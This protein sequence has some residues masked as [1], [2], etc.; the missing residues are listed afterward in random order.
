METNP[1]KELWVSMSKKEAVTILVA[2]GYWQDGLKESGGKA[3][4][5]V[6]FQEFQTAALS[7]KEL[8][9]LTTR[10]RRNL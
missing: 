8:G 3:I 9:R 5:T 4:P 10:L 2:L 7:V 6:L 1:G